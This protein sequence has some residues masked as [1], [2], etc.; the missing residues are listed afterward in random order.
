I[1]DY[2]T[3]TAYSGDVQS[4]VGV[5]SESGIRLG[6][7]GSITSSGHVSITSEAAAGYSAGSEQDGWWQV[8]G[9]RMLAF[10]PPSTFYNYRFQAFSNGLE[11]YPPQDET[12]LWPRK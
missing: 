5:Y 4:S 2:S 11:I 6:A 7:D 3:G 1:G 12:L 10:Y 8:R 9:N